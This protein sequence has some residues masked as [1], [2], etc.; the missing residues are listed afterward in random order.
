MWGCPSR[1]ASCVSGNGVVKYQFEC[2]HDLIGPK[3][4]KQKEKDAL[5]SLHQHLVHDASHNSER[6][7][8]R[9]TIRNGILD[10]TKMSAS[11]R[12]GNLLILLCLSHTTSGIDLLQPGWGRNHISK[13]QFQD[14]IKLQ[15]GFEKWVNES[16]TIEEVREAS[17][18]LSTLIESIKHCFPRE[19]GN[20]WQ[21][22]KIHSLAKMLYYM[23]KFG[24]AK[25]FSGQ[26]GERALK[27]IVKDHAN[28]T[29]GRADVFA[30]QLAAR[31]FESLVNE[32][33]FEDIKPTLG[34]DYVKVQ[35]KDPNLWVGRGKFSASFQACDRHGRGRVQVCWSD[36]NKEKLNIGISDSF[37]HAIRTFACDN[38]WTGQFD[39]IGYTAFKMCPSGVDDHVTFYASEYLNGGPWYDFAMIQFD[40]D[41]MSRADCVSPARVLGFFQY[42]TAGVPT[43]KLINE[44]GHTPEEINDHWMHDKS[45][46]AVVHTAT[47]YVPWSKIEADFVVPFKLGPINNHIYIVNVDNIIDP[48]FAF[49]DYGGAG[50]DSER[51]FCVLPNRKWGRYFGN[52]I[53]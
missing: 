14:C 29:Q 15:L 1:N 53:T 52:R 10:G 17:T 49:K 46:Y 5:D 41:N 28:Q 45:M 30:E 18:L 34:L 8:P 51:Y 37:V 12:I 3:Q 44:E 25:N 38:R 23:L 24:K 50:A 42:D 31:E 11:E 9:M 2:V 19:R 20:G 43:P 22:P 40:E 21:I 7:F 33:A 32:W 39:I 27:G 4:S 6:D 26:I 13:K 47:S 35:N 16:N 48:L 36:R